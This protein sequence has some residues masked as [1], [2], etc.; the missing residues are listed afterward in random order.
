MKNKLI[1][2]LLPMLVLVY[3]CDSISK[4]SKQKAERYQ[5]NIES[6]KRLTKAKDSIYN[7]SL[8]GFG[9]VAKYSEKE[10]L[11]THFT[12][13]QEKLNLAS[14][15][16][17]KW[18][19][20]ALDKNESALEPKLL[21]DL[22][23][24]QTLINEAVKS[25]DYPKE[26]LNLLNSIEKNVD[27]Y[28]ETSDKNLTKSNLLLVATQKL[29][30][31]Y[32]G[33][34]PERAADITTLVK[35]GEGHYNLLTTLNDT[36]HAQ[37]SRKKDGGNY[38][39]TVIA[40]AYN[41]VT[42]QT[43]KVTEHNTKMKSLLPELDDSYSKTLKDMKAVFFI[44]VGRTSWDSYSDY[45]SEENY[46]YALRE[47]DEETFKYFDGLSDNAVL[48]S[49][50]GFGQSDI[51]V[52]V[53][54]SM[55]KKL[56]INPTEKY[57][58]GDDDAEFWL[59]DAVVK[60]YHQYVTETNGKIVDNTSWEEVPED[61]FYDNL[62]HLG[63]TIE[64]KPVGFFDDEA[65]EEATPAGMPYVGNPAY[66]E[67]KKDS[68]GNDFWSFYGKYMLINQLLGGN[69][70]SRYEYDD[71]NKR[72][73]NSGTPYYGSNGQHKYGTRGTSFTNTKSYANSNY[74]KSYAT[75]TRSDFGHTNLKKSYRT[76]TPSARTGSARRGGGPGGRGK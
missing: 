29:G 33:R 42:A 53:D 54:N 31:T 36:L 55:W 64:S 26:R 28:K 25:S 21:K 74:R 6:T 51:S 4:E 22:A 65:T 59:N 68:S 46:L 49:E 40:D 56:N 41:G 66:G 73:R 43:A 9:E 19:E 14:A 48:A 20:P 3:S 69:N 35:V 37:H 62:E 61:D 16:Y 2:I 30:E 38:S 71:Y 5:A 34:Y 18:V 47:V 72:Y 70:F 1:M 23:T 50:Y 75:N 52:K 60:Y 44:Q 11:Q 32:K 7:A 24:I 58:S 39:L 67:W 10:N 15:T 57:P 27:G 76:Q 63:M 8:K 45:A 17:T 13:A 12:V